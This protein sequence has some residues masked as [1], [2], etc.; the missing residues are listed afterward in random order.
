MAD[1]WNDPYYPDAERVPY[2]ISFYNEDDSLITFYRLNQPGPPYSDTGTF[3]TNTPN[4]ITNKNINIYINGQENAAIRNDLY[5]STD[6]INK[7]SELIASI[8]YGGLSSQTT[9]FIK[10]D[11]LDV[12]SY[13]QI[14]FLIEKYSGSY[15]ETLQ[16][17]NTVISPK[18]QIQFPAQIQIFCSTPDSQI[19]YTTD[20]SEP[21]KQ[22]NLYSDI[23][24]VEEGTTIK[25]KAYKEGY[26][27]SD[28]S[29]LTI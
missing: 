4:I 2:S 9:E 8:G 24:E 21:N 5:I 26:I 20:N 17:K 12:T 18:I 25:A 1:N 10:I 7:A 29:F 28:I 11:T 23:F 6:G 3:S 22:S 27:E 14:Y 15:G 13:N 16:Y 19:Y